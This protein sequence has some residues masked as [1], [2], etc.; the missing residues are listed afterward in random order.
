MFIVAPRFN[1]IPVIHFGKGDLAVRFNVAA[2]WRADLMVC[3]D[4]CGGL[5]DQARVRPPLTLIRTICCMEM[6][7]H[8]SQKAAQRIL[9]QLKLRDTQSQIAAAQVHALIAVAE[10]LHEVARAIEK[11]GGPAVAMPA[12]PS[13]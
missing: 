7:R 11:L 9:E 6:D 4:V 5:L 1:D 8:Q 3:T 2:K 10:Q 12:V 13:T